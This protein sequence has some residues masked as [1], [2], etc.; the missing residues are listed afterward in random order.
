MTREDILARVK[1]NELG[2]DDAL[3]LLEKLDRLRPPAPPAP[4]AA[5][6]NPPR[7]QVAE[8]SGWCSV[9]FDGLWRPCTLPSKLWLELLEPENS[10]RF[11]KFL[12]DNKSKFRDKK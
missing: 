9:Y 1:R 8:K 3:I 10:E 11:K 12:E 5:A 7:F 4:P 2:T 6:R